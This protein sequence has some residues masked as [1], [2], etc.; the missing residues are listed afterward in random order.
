LSTTG[1]FVFKG[2][3]VNTTAGNLIDIAY[4]G[5]DGIQFFETPPKVQDWGL[6]EI[7]NA[8][9]TNFINYIE[10]SGI[11]FTPAMFD[12][13]TDDSPIKSLFINADIKSF[14]AVLAPFQE[15]FCLPTL[16]VRKV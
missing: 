2:S 13:M 11:T 14:P 12:N 10:N 15:L 5:I 9:E 16:R 1:G 3:Q 8:T 6:S 7:P 4:V